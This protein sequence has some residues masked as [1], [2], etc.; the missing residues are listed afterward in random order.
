MTVKYSE[1]LRLNS[2]GISRRNIA[3]S[4]PCSRNTVAKTLDRAKDLGISWPL[5]DGMTDA[6]LGKLLFNQ[7]E[8]T[9][10]VTRCKCQGLFYM[11]R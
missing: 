9:A 2:I 1:I 3:L 10:K 4:V 7:E 6:N 11:V 5:P 8:L